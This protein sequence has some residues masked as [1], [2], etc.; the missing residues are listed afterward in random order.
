M[1][2]N[3]H[4]MVHGMPDVLLIDAMPPCRLVDV[5]RGIVLR[6]WNPAP[7]APF[8]P[9]GIYTFG[10]SRSGHVPGRL[11]HTGNVTLPVFF[12]LPDGRE[13][14]EPPRCAF[15]DQLGRPIRPEPRESAELPRLV[16]GPGLYVCELCVRLC[17][18]IFEEDDLRQA[19]GD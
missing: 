19:G 8:A 6:N 9:S 4:R 3:H 12:R 13:F 7:E 14:P 10:R 1:I 2:F 11:R 18:E 5:H 15:C 16:A 17:T